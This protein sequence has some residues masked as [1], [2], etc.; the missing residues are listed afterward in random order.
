MSAQSLWNRLRELL[1]GGMRQRV[2]LAGLLYTAALLM[3]G[4]AAFASANNLLF[5][6]LAAMLATFLVSGFISRLDLAA[7]ELDFQLPEHV[8]ARR[9]F[10]GR[11]TV[12]NEKRWMPSFSV[13]LT[14][15]RN[16][17][18]SSRLY[19]PVIPGGATVEERIEVEF[20][21]RGLHRDSSFHFST[22]FPFGFTERRAQVHLRR[23]VLVYPCLDPRP[24]FETLLASIQGDLDSQ[25]RGHSGDFYRIRPYQYME[26]A[27]HVDWKASAHSREIQVREFTR[28][29]DPLIHLYLDLNVP[30]AHNEWFERAVDCCAFLA[31]R[32]AAHGSRIH[33]RT[34][35]FALR[36]P[37]DGDVYTMLKYLAVV[38]PL[39]GRMPGAPNDEPGVQLAFTPSPELMHD[40]GWQNARL[41]GPGDFLPDG[42]LA[43]SGGPGEPGRR[44][45]GNGPHLHHDR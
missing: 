41:L 9:K 13:H 39:Q 15:A 12:H 26:S 35:N 18:F 38:A 43:A 42:A 7:L 34:Q 3:V 8:S 22:R 20:A 16:N 29:Q 44:R 32:I 21:R 19:F 33:F 36:L 6:L 25:L 27:R 10:T 23:E 2:T 17:G 40:A 30:P 11:I 24:G 1:H 14:G 37:E 45:A 31:W 28:E 5:L 4:L